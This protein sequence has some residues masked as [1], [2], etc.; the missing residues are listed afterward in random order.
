MRLQINSARLRLVACA[1]DLVQ[2]ALADRA[3]LEHMIRARVPDDWPQ[4]DLRD[5]LPAYAKIV[6]PEDAAAGWGIWLPVLE[7]ERVVIG[8]IGFKG[9]PRDGMVEIGYS[10][11]PAFRR[12]GYAGEAARA[13]VAWA[14]AQPGVD[15]V[16]AE[17]LDANV[18]SIG[19][20]EKIGMQR[21]GRTEEGLLWEV[22][23]DRLVVE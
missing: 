11:L 3:E 9:A 23:R 6:G 19:V 12:H 13:L 18:A 14:L 2:V 16:T 15:R 21:I 22:R 5:F 7:T 20:L 17:C 10:V 8:D 4:P 1:V